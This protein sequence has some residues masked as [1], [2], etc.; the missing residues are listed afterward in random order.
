MWAERLGAPFVPRADRSLPELI[1]ESAAEAALVISGGGPRLLR[2]SDGLDYFFHPNM[3]KLRLHNVRAGR[4]DPM[5]TAM[6]LQPGDTVLDCTL[7]R[8][9]DA[10]VASHALGEGARII[11][12][13]VVPIIAELTRHGLRHYESGIARLDEPMRRIEVHCANHRAYLA[14]CDPAT[15]DVVYFDPIFTSPIEKSQAMVPLRAIADKSTVTPD[16]LALA[17]RVARRRVVMKNVVGSSLWEELG[18]R[19]FVKGSSSRIEYGIVE[20]QG[21]DSRNTES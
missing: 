13:E 2:P 12:L 17:R 10:I 3:A 7:G 18:I 15:F 4:G 16:T 11:G 21:G 19:R 1:Q 5:L 20:A 8:A 9:S 6:E 14:D